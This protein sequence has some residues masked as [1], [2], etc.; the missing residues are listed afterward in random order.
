MRPRIGDLEAEQALIGAALMDESVPDRVALT[1]E[2]FTGME[3]KCA[4]RAIL[5]LRAAGKPLDSLLVA[6]C[7]GISPVFLGACAMSTPTADNAEYYADIVRAHAL[8]RAV[9]AAT[10]AVQEHHRRGEFAGPELLDLALKLIT[11]IDVDR[12]RQAL[13]I[14]DLVRERFAELDAI[15]EARARGEDV[16]TG[17][18]L[19][20]VFY[21]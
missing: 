3:S 11:A 9:L 16:R 17:I 20:R 18:R 12:P 15:A 4:W 13:T 5:T 2:H 6:E 8:T 19:F 21:G 1:A 10:G 14:G 7:A